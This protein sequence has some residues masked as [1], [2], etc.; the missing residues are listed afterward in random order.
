MVFIFYSIFFSSSFSNI[1]LWY[2]YIF[3][4]SRIDMECLLSS[5]YFVWS[6]IR[7]HKTSKLSGMVCIVKCKLTMSIVQEGDNSVL[8]EAFVQFFIFDLKF[9]SLLFQLFLKAMHVLLGWLTL[10]KILW[11][12]HYCHIYLRSVCFTLLITLFPK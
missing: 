6:A 4:K 7:T 2:L 1:S 11:F 10:H 9:P 8:A 3:P 12:W 5:L